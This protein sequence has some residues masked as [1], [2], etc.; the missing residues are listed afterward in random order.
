MFYILLAISILMS[1]LKNILSKYGD[2]EFEG[3]PALFKLNG[4]IAL[5]TA[6]MASIMGGHFIGNLNTS[7][8]LLCIVNAVAVILA[9]VFFIKSVATGSVTISSLFYACGFIIPTIFG[10]IYYHEKISAV[11][12]IGLL[13][14]CVGLWMGS[15]KDNNDKKGFST[16]W[17]FLA[18]FSMFFSGI[19][20]VIQKIFSM[21]KQSHLMND[22]LV[23][24]FTIMFL[25]TLIL[26]MYK[27]K[28]IQ[29]SSSKFYTLAVFMGLATG[30]ISMLNIYLTGKLPSIIVFPVTNGGIIVVTAL[31]SD[32][33]FREKLSSR[34]RWSVLLGVAAIFVI[35][36][37]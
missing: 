7:S 32:I 26:Y 6:A 9:Q 28:G 23:T 22:F 33:V 8:V 1:V 13:V 30:F 18:I 36:I 11:Q 10:A 4:I 34:Q 19:L 20:G 16:K 37:F 27:N 15:G 24:S 2:A 5:V 3:M 12:M 29:K 35:G 14:L 21:S 25:F 17:L 31:A